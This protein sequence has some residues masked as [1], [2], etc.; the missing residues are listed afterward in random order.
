MMWGRAKASQGG[1][2]AV[3]RKSV[4][5]FA[6]R[7]VGVRCLQE[8]LRLQAQG[9]VAVAAVRTTPAG[10]KGWWSRPGEP[11]VYDVAREVGIPILEADQDLLDLPVDL[12]FSVFHPAILKEPL[13]SHPRQGFV[14]LHGA[15]LPRYR[16]CNVVTH[17][18]IN[19]EQRW[20]PTL[21]LIDT[22]I[23][24]GPIIRVGWF[25]VPPGIS[26]RELAEATD[27][28]GFAVFCA[29]LTG[30]LAGSTRGTPQDQII[31]ADGITPLYHRRSSL[32]GLKELDPAW[33]LDQIDRYVRAFDFPPFEPA[34][35]RLP[36]GRKLYL[37]HEKGRQP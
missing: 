12:A 4:A 22:G 8:L 26:A 32:N 31:Q 23:D 29:E 19:G 2:E 11:E 6:T 10:T 5:L 20:G 30:L 16:G 24:T 17:G 9:E 28:V 7:R 3:A 13:I 35:F 27:E 15:P 18:L 21:H 25:D 14:N 37:V 33:P 34:F 36:D 1:C